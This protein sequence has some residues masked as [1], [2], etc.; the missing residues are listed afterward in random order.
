VTQ[1]DAI[2]TRFEKRATVGEF[3]LK[4]LDPLKDAASS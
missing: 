3:D 1:V 2:H 4:N